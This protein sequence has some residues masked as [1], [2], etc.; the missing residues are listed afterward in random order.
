MAFMQFH[1]WPSELP[2]WCALKPCKL[3]G[4]VTCSDSEKQA[5]LKPAPLGQHGGH[6]ARGKQEPA[7]LSSPQHRALLH[8]SSAERGVGELAENW[9][10][11]AAHTHISN[12]DVKE[13]NLGNW[14]WNSLISIH[15]SKSMHTCIS[16]VRK[17]KASPLKYRSSFTLQ[18]CLQ[19]KS[20]RTAVLKAL[21]ENPFESL[22]TFHRYLYYFSSFG[23]CF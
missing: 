1:C 4:Q 13:F 21:T 19:K 12:A 17:A 9:R 3:S 10:C 8:S 22:E 15:P 18:C 16:V 5:G 14:G 7:R 20:N 2:K 11:Q 23:V 6:G